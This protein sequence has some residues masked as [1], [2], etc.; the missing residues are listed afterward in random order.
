MKAEADRY[1]RAAF[2]P[3]ET[4]AL[5]IEVQLKENLSA[6]ILEWKVETAN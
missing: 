3:V 2:T 6:G 4:T 1:N 5:R